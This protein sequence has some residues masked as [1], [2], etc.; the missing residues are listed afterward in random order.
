[1]EQTS[2][3]LIAN[4]R[5]WLGTG[6]INFFGLP[7]AGKDTQGELLAG[8]L[9]APVIGGGEILRN[10]VIPEHVRDTINKGGLAPTEDYLNI[11]LPYLAKP[12]FAGKPLVLS[13]VGRWSGEE[14]GVIQAAAKADH[15]I[16]AVVF[17][18]LDE[19]TVWKRFEESQR[20]LH[21]SRGPRH[22]DAAD[23][24]E[25]R[26]E[27]FRVKTLPVIDFYRSLGLVIDV[28]SDRSIEAVQTEI[29][30]QLD[31]RASAD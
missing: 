29:I 21:Q 2:Q 28:D 11:I 1:M 15:P 23:I 4:I 26:L 7:F 30:H 13:S 16:K 24:I 17:L 25:K 9:G 14:Q 10:S 27:E 12:E 19:R 6:S 22:D 3:S 8:E 5:E 20:N 31:R 18:S